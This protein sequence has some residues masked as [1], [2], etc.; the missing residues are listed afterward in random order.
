MSLTVKCF[1]GVLRNGRRVV[2]TITRCSNRGYGLVIDHDWDS[3]DAPDFPVFS[4]ESAR[5]RARFGL[6][7]WTNEPQGWAV[8]LDAYGLPAPLSWTDVPLAPACVDP[9]AAL[10]RLSA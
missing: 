8:V 6:S 5:D 7:E 9:L 3:P 10:E 2:V 4:H 1:D